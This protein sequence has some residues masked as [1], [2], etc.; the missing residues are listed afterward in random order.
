M[1]AQRA[2]VQRSWSAGSGVVTADG[3][4]YL[5]HTGNSVI[6]I[7]DSDYAVHKNQ[8][9]DL[10]TNSANGGV[11]AEALEHRFIGRMVRK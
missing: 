7:A 1:A 8:G 4:R 10:L 11:T 3:R 5:Y 9:Y 6:F 2:D